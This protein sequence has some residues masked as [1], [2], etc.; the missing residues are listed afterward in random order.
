[1]ARSK[2]ISTDYPGVRYYT[3][4]RRLYRKK[5]DECYFIRYRVD[6]KQKEEPV[7]WRSEGMTALKASEIRADLMRAVR[8]GDGPRTLADKR[9]LRQQQEIQRQQDEEE[10][11]KNSLTFDQVWERYYQNAKKRNAKS[12]YERA[13]SLYHQWIKPVIGDVPLIDVD[14]DH[15]VSIRDNLM[16]NDRAPRTIQYAIGVVRQVFN[17]ARDFQLY[18]GVSPTIAFKKELPKLDNWRARFL[19]KNEAEKLLALLRKINRTVYQMAVLSFDSGLRRGEIFSLTWADVDLGNKMLLLKKTKTKKTR[20]AFLTKRSLIMLKLKALK[21]HSPNDLVFPGSDNGRIKAISRNFTY[22]VNRLGLNKGIT[23][24]RQKVVFHTLRHSYCS[25]LAQEGH[26]LG[27]LRDLLGHK[28]LLMT[29][30]YLHFSDE[31]LK[32]SAETMDQIHKD[33]REDSAQRAS[34]HKEKKPQRHKLKLKEDTP[35]NQ[36][37]AK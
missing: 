24:R 32:Q 16:G 13:K 25:L 22:A 33:Y 23:D 14:Q 29:S 18:N 10:R 17:Y 15:L 9:K 3:N 7:G 2:K 35:G 26:T 6:G 31:R 5:P 20:Y 37:V 27:E 1:M 28:T 12:T 11:Q 30:R 19:T 34:K 4:D 36:S 8:T 21:S